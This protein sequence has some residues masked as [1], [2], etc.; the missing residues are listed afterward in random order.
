M[1]MINDATEFTAKFA[2]ALAGRFL[3]PGRYIEKPK[4][5][6]FDGR[7]KSYVVNFPLFNTK[8]YN[9]IIKNWQFLFLLTYQNTP[10]RVTKDVINP[11]VQYEAYIPGSWYS[12]FTSITDMTVNFR[13]ARREMDIPVPFLDRNTND[14]EEWLLQKRMIRTVIPDAYEVSIT[15]TEIFGETQNSLYHLLAQ[16]SDSK[17]V[18]G[19]VSYQ[20][21]EIVPG[22]G[23]DPLNFN[24]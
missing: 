1:G 16:S 9:E 15:L 2:G 22:Q 13:G 19:E 14:G 6:A 21:T 5:F 17:I 18:T 11:P 3:E 10:G 24:S 20:G 7:Q 12:K 4:N 23:M 8:S